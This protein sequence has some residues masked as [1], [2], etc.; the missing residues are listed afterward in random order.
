MTEAA[1]AQPSCAV[2][3]RARQIPDVRDGM[4]L[5]HV[6]PAGRSAS[7]PT[8][9]AV[10]LGPLGEGEGARGRRHGSELAAS[11]RS[12]E[13]GDLVNGKGL[14]AR[15]AVMVAVGDEGGPIE[16]GQMFTVMPMADHW[17]AWMSMRS[18]GCTSMPP[19]GVTLRYRRLGRAGG[20][21]SR[22]RCSRELPALDRRLGDSAPRQLE[23][24]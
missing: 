19:I 5:D 3:P 17:Q 2:L 11:S 18:T 14:A 16:G 23:R 22:R 21:S 7:A 12:G 10:Q 20:M 9:S 15:G 24:G 1:R 6:S 8:L 4:S 13:W